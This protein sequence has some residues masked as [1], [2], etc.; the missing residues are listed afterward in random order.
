MEA[1]TILRSIRTPGHRR[2]LLVRRVLAAVLIIGAGLSALHARRELPQAVVFARDVPAGSALQAEDLTLAPVP[3]HILPD[4]AVDTDLE[5]LEGRVVVAAAASGELVTDARLLS[6]E[7]VDNLV[8]NSTLNTSGEKS[9]MIPLKLAEPDIL[10]H[11]HH[12]D[13]VNVIAGNS[14]S[15]LIGTT[16]PAGSVIAAG[17]RVVATTSSRDG[18]DASTLLLALPA[19]QADAV[20]SA[21]LSQPL[22]VVIVG[23]R[24]TG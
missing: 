24:A 22:T 1:K 14:N 18:E 16:S 5:K 10:P 15:D 3:S 23:Q 8:N 6:P 11:L 2:S 7:L 21:S 9:H 19:S 17:G 20:A 4:S 13:T 12:G